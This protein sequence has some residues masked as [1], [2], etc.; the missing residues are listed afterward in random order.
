MRRRRFWRRLVKVI[1]LG[2]GPDRPDRGRPG[3]VRLHGRHRQ[4]HGRAADQGPGRAVLP[5][6]DRRDADSE[7]QHPA[8]R[9]R[10][11]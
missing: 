9:A 1:G 6:V 7:R 10:S 11:R 3:L 2:T 4:R 5:S 8:R